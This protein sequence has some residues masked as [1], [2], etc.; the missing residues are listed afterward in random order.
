MFAWF[1]KIIT[2]NHISELLNMQLEPTGR[3][4][5]NYGTRSGF[6]STQAV[7]TQ[8]I[9]EAAIHAFAFVFS[10]DNVIITP[11]LCLSLGALRHTV[12]TSIIAAKIVSL[13]FFLSPNISVRS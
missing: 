10:W 1:N 11:S 4:I 7:T 9:S 6:I 8:R 5:H 12:H 2:S 13:R 3:N